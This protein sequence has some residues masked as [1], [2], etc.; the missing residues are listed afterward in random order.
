MFRLFPLTDGGPG[1]SAEKPPLVRLCGYDADHLCEDVTI[2]GIYANGR[3]MS[4]D[5]LALTCNEFTRN[6]RIL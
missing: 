4:K 5:E 2:D 6:I 1:T 3:R